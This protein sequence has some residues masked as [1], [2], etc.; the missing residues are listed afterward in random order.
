M[1]VIKIK[2]RRILFDALHLFRSVKLK[3]WKL[4]RRKVC[5]LYT[6]YPRAG[7]FLDGKLWTLC[8]VR[9]C[10]TRQDPV[11]CRHMHNQIQILFLCDQDELRKRICCAALTQSS[12]SCRNPSNRPAWLG[13]EPSSSF[14]P[15]S[16]SKLRRVPAS[17]RDS[18]VLVSFRL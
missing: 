15:R 4:I 8:N 16:V 2:K 9:C 10:N 12:V 6:L 18:S 5:I 14:Q 7:F 1:A 3:M 17:F 13:P 11:V